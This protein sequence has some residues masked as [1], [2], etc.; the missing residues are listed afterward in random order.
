M[1]S[2]FEGC[3]SLTTIT[4]V[5]DFKSCKI[6]YYDVFKYCDNLTS[7]KVKNL[8]VDID[9]FCRDAKIDKSKVTVVS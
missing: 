9:T 3:R 2:M 5:L 1:Y 4:G 7:V 6:Y 8:P